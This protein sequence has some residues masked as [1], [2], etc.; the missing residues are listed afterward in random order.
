M[1]WGPPGRSA[2]QRACEE[3]EAAELQAEALE[4]YKN[5]YGEEPPNTREGRRRFA[6]VKRKTGYKRGKRDE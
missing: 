5:K 2:L 1:S 4:V 3:M 6:T